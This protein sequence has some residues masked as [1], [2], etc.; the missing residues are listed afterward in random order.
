ATDGVLPPWTEWWDEEDL[1]G[2]F[3]DTRTRRTIVAEQPRLPLAYFEQTVPVPAHWD[4]LPCV[5]VQF[6][7][8]Y[9]EDARRARDQGWRVERIPEEH[10]HML[11]DPTRVAR[12]LVEAA[13]RTGMGA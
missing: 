6:N 11:V 12:S 9:D 4:D 3:P 8:A 10:L 7:A 1:R 5:Y 13:E 2:L